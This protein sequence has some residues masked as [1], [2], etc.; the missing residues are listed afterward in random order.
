MGWEIWPWRGACPL[1]SGQNVEAP[2][3]GAFSDR[4]SSGKKLALH[5]TYDHIDDLWV[6]VV[7]HLCGTEGL[8]QI[9]VLR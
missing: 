5:G 4:H 7:E 2:E 6:L 1:D 9:K 3:Y 8:N